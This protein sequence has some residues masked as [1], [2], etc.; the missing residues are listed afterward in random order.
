[1][2]VDD[3]T[4]L[5]IHRL[6]QQS[7]R[8]FT[9]SELARFNRPRGFNSEALFPHNGDLYLAATESGKKPYRVSDLSGTPTLTE[10]TESANLDL[11]AATTLA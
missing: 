3:G 11:D 1:M 7:N 10:M 9:Y 2:V 6:A 8:S 5:L 4:R